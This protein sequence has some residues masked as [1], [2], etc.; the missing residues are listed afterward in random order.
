[1]GMPGTPSSATGVATTAFTLGPAVAGRQIVVSRDSTNGDHFSSASSSNR[2]SPLLGTNGHSCPNRRISACISP[3]IRRNIAR[4][5]G[6][7]VW[8]LPANERFRKLD[9]AYRE[10]GSHPGGSNPPS[11]IDVEPASEARLLSSSVLLNCISFSQ[12]LSKPVAEAVEDRSDPVRLSPSGAK[13][14]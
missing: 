10:P 2:L 1:M 7:V 3:H 8:F 4:L 5:A 9:R 11:S 12:L 13:C 14:M 6:S